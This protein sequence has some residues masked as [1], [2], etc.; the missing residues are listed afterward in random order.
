MPNGIITHYT[1]FLE[2]VVIFNGS[3]LSH[4]LIL[5]LRDPQTFFLEAYNSAG[6]ARYRDYISITL[7]VTMTS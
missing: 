6:S 5:D 1:L 3:A 2:G 7:T 4:T